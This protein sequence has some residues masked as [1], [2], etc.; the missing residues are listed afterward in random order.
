MAGWLHCRVT[1]FFIG[2]SHW[3]RRGKSPLS[4]LGLATIIRAW[5]GKSASNGLRFYAS[6]IAGIN[7]CTPNTRRNSFGMKR[8]YPK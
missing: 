2:R 3:A 8:R 5:A 4:F 1:G 6:R 7:I